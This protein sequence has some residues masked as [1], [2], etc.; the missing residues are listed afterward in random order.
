MGKNGG[1]GLKSEIELQ[2]QGIKYAGSKKRLI[3]QIL[4]LAKET[5]AQSVWDGFSGT[6]R[7]AGFR[8]G[9]VPHDLQRSFCLVGSFRTVLAPEPTETGRVRGTHRAPERSTAA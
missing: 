1:V 3:P 4:S 8:A 6:T 7:L 5:G 9:G 2:T